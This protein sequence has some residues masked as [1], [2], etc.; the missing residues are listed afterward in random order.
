MH[1]S[2]GSLNAADSERDDSLRYVKLS[3]WHNMAQY[4]SVRGLEARWVWS[5]TVR[6]GQKNIPV[7]AGNRNS[8]VQPVVH[9]T[10]IEYG[11]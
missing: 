11:V 2:R 4:R 7:P 6:D 10:M 1:S 5:R 8:A 9:K 3:L